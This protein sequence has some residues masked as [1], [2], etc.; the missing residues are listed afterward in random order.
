M[1]FVYP[2]FLWA[3]TALSIPIII[4][5][6]NFRK[7]I[8][9]YFS[10]TRFL[11]QVKQET[12]QK[13][14]LKQYLVLASRLLFIFFLVIAFAQPFLPSQEDTSTVRNISIYLDNSL[15][16]SV[17]S[18]G[19]S[20]G[21]EEGIKRALALVNLFPNETRF[22]LITN[23]LEGHSLKTKTETT[24]L[25]SQV[26]LSPIS[27]SAAEVLRKVEKNT[28]LFWISDFQKS[29]FGNLA[30]PDSSIQIRLVPIGL[31]KFSNIF[32]DSIYLENPF[33]IGGDKN[34]LKVKLR[35]SGKREVSGLV[36]KLSINGVQS[37]GTS[38][39]ISPES[40]ETVSFDL[41]A[42]M[43]GIN[44]GVI[45]F[46]DYPV[47]F[48]NEFYFT[49]NFTRKLKIIEVKPSGT[50]DYIQK[51]FGNSALFSLQSFAP[52]NLNYSKLAEADL[53][54]L[55]ELDRID[56]AM[57]DAIHTYENEFGALLIIPSKE[58]D[59]AS[60]NSVTGLSL[61]RNQSTD[62]TSLNKPDFKNPFFQN[63]L[64]ET[65]VA[66][67]MPKAMTF[68]EWTDRN[69]LLEVNNHK[70]FLSKLN[71]TFLLASPLDKTFT[72]FYS[73]ALFLPIM[74]RIASSGKKDLQK[75]YYTVTSNVIILP[76]DSLP[77]DI[78]V[79]LTG[80]T[81]LVPPQRKSGGQVMLEIP[82][83]SINA[84]F[85]QLTL[86]SDTL[87]L[88][89]FDL[90]KNES[91]LEQFKPDEIKATL[92]GGKQIRFFEP[93][94][95]EKFT[96]QIKERYLGKYLWKE[97]ILLALLFLLAEVLLIRFL[98]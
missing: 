38:V 14:R 29:T 34:A 87:G 92:G 39:D 50:P 71:K 28:T 63:I 6:F 13:R 59:L 72:D 75:L 54:V 58:P 60:Y 36:T 80:A 84:G 27:R 20:K 74:Y 95:A 98:K 25:L 49:M 2:S 85:Y 64:E 43:K 26:R 67:S 69:A 68:I 33:T 48:D 4:H 24:D 44:K 96:S 42:G 83:F 65:N 91:M 51:V 97:A 47:S 94:S 12:T 79:K 55:N 40:S 21:L 82:R 16:L 37:A 53:V 81:E 89:A 1:S 77:A 73:H 93:S 62:L 31:E 8:R 46:S 45:S 41:N 61:K 56:A 35:N 5:L 18:D 78:P 22:Q 7:T 3:L 90:D 86:K 10:D 66:I 76:N 17:P 23:E 57:R 32:I 70:P 9:V 88:I 11:K 15:S 30:P 19:K 52:G